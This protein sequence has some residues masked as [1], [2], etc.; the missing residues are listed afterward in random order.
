MNVYNNMIVNNVSTHEGGGIGLNDAPNVRVYNNTIMKNLT[1]ATAVTSNGQ[2]APAGLSTSANSDQLQA[3]LPARLA[4]ASATR[5]CST[6]SSGTTAP[7]PGPARRSP[8]SALPGDAS[9]IDHWD[10]GVSDGTG[11]LAPTNSIVQQDA[12]DHPYTT[13]PTNSS[14][15]P[16]V[17]EPYDV[18]VVLRHLA[19][20]PGLR[21]RHPGGPGGA[22]EPAGRL[23]PGG[24][25]AS[26]ACNLGAASKACRP[27]SSRLRLAAPAVDFDDQARPALGGFDSGA[28]EFG[29][30]RPPPP[31]SSDLYFST[32]G[33]TNPPGVAGTADDADIYSWNGNGVQ[34]VDRRHSR[35]PIRP[36][37]AVRT[38]TATT[39]WT[40]PLLPVVQRRCHHPCLASA[41][42]RRTRT[43]STTTPAPGRCASTAVRT[44]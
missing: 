4:R 25:P 15:D 8:A 7:A 1:T 20:E 34:P 35:A 44:V 30:A 9:P 13:S 39:G 21:G 36:A 18:S 28:D 14:A 6:T 3:T 17:V 31:P 24:C 32:F 23:P 11:S 19:T 10:M 43:S 27:T 33:N 22:A 37:G 26:P 29:A 40:Q 5:C 38:S 2:P 42:G 16:A 12:G 41:C